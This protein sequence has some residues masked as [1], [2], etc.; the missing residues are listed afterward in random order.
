MAARAS[1]RVHTRARVRADTAPTKSYTLY[2]RKYQ[3]SAKAHNTKH[4]HA[5]T[6]H[7]TH[8]LVRRHARVLDAH[9][10]DAHRYTTKRTHTAHSTQHAQHTTHAP[11]SDSTYGYSTFSAGSRSTPSLLRCTMRDQMTASFTALLGLDQ[12]AMMYTKTC[13]GSA[14][15]VCVCVCVCACV[16][17]R[18]LGGEWRRRRTSR[19]RCLQR[20]RDASRACPVDARPPQANSKTQ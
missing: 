10:L 17:A 1:L 19:C 18:A 3:T 14:A 8:T 16:R 11:W 15:A 7:T 20:A 13:R 4:M 5:H 12:R 9:R 2:A 6:Q